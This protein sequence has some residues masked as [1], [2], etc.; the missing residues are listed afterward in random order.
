MFKEFL[1]LLLL[2]HIVGDFYIQTRAM[3]AKKEK[4]LAWV[5]IHCLCYL[6]FMFLLSLPILSWGIV[7]GIIVA[8]LSHF[9]IDV[10][11]YLFTLWLNKKNKMTQVIERNLFF[12]D[13][14]LH[15]ICLVSIAY[16]AVMN[17]LSIRVWSHM[18]NF[19]TEI[20][21]SKYY[22][23]TWIL[24][25]LIIHKPANIA[26]SKLLMIYKPVNSQEDTTREHNAGRF[27]GT[28]ER[29]IMLIF[30]VIGELSAIGLVLTAKSIARYDRISKERDFAEYY[31]LG[32]LI[33][34]VIVILCS[35]LFKLF[36]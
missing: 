23:L 19:F 35:F 9:I 20:G 32:T 28:V 17:E 5:L 3:A 22:A 11:K 6:G 2:G 33:S 12:L 31:L 34:T 18:S 13:L 26:I 27:I 16:W 25:I 8:A 30:L 29:I 7:L 21:L 36:K 1:I 10:S 14:I 24:T 15:G 4:S